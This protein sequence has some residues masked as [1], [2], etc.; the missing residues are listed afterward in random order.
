MAD[1]RNAIFLSYASQDAEAARGIC[2]SL[3]AAGIEVFF[4]QSELR[5]GDAWDQ[6]IRAQVRDCISKSTQARPEGYF[7][8]EWRLADQRTHLMGRRRT[9]LVPVCI[10]ETR[11]VDADVP[12]SFSASQWMRLPVGRA[13][14]EFVE[15]IQHLLSPEP[16][17]TEQASAGSDRPPAAATVASTRARKRRKLVVPAIVAI[18][19]IA[20]CGSVLYRLFVSR[21]SAAAA[22]RPPP[23]SIAVL[24]FVNMS[25]DKDQDYFSDGLTEE[26]LNSLARIN[27][28]Q[29]AARTSAFSFKDRD[30]NMGTVARQLN[31]ASILEGSVRRS[32]H[33]VRITAQLINAVTGFHLWSQTYDRDLGHVLKLQT[34]IANA[35][36]GALKVKLLANSAVKVELGG[37]SNPAAFD[38][39]LKGLQLARIAVSTTPIVCNGPVDAFSEAIALDPDYALAYANRAVI[40][41]ACATNSPDWLSLQQPDQ[42]SVRADAERA[43]AIAP[44]L[45]EGYVA[46]SELEVGLLHFGAAGDACAHALALAPGSTL[47]LNRCSLLAAYSGQAETAI[48]GARHA[49]ALDPLDSLSHR[50]LGDTLRLARR[51][52]EAV[53]AYQDSIAIDHEHSAE[54]YGLRGLTYYSAG[55]LSA[56]QSS[57]E[58][59]RD[60][61]RSRVCLAIVYHGL[62]RQA[63][64]SEIF[65]KLQ[66]FAGEASAYQYAEIKAQWGDCQEALEWLERAYKLRDPGMAYAKRDPLLDP[67]RAQPRFKAILSELSYPNDPL[68]ESSRQ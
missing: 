34:D 15:R 23:H 29:V 60:N 42:K 46:L 44:G 27:E 30:V 28:L 2:E 16:A 11:E 36:T 21:Q 57:C 47:V 22:F 3:R 48:A 49:V 68:H 24:P 17:R 25:G 26:L 58:R 56:A 32:G 20:I 45:A 18:I 40:T 37:T 31:V 5:G 64:A 7:R 63:D 39:Y 8:L 51:Y 4:D 33:T 9:F 43:I 65:A 12:D 53:A 10:D 67:L 59:N 66:Q 35:V 55:N 1:G 41:W 54:S 52:D 6:K 38:A 50:T 61:Y 14:P 13:T 19:V 62:N